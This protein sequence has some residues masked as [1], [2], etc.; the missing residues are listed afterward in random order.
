MKRKLVLLVTSTLLLLSLLVGCGG[1][2]G[3]GTNVTHTVSYSHEDLADEFVY[4]MEMDL[5]YTLDLVKV[6]TREYDYIVVYDYDA[7]AYDAYYIGDYHVGEDLGSYLDYYDNMFYYYL[8]FIG[9]D[10]GEPLYEDYVTGTIF[11]DTYAKSRSSSAMQERLSKEFKQARGKAIAEK[12]NLSHQRAEELVTLA[13]NYKAM[14]RKGTL[15]QREYD[16]FAM[17]IVGT[18]ATDLIQMGKENNVEE[19]WKALERAAKHNG[20]GVEHVQTMLLEDF[21]LALRRPSSQS[22]K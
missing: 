5:G 7:D 3:G 18:S 21:G 4:R 14:W 9:Y 12:F 16:A 1:G 2:G 17:E 19:G 20:T 11:E 15:T 6:D 22:T 10:A 13:M 8:D